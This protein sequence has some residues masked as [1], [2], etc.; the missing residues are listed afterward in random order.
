MREEWIRS[1]L[2]IKEFLTSSF[3]V[4]QNQILLVDSVELLED[5]NILRHHNESVAMI[6]YKYS[7]C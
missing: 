4:T 2:V 6:I 7:I 5:W 1:N 3:W